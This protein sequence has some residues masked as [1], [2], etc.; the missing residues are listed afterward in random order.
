LP[1]REDER[2]Q[3]TGF[4]VCLDFKK[5]SL[6]N[7]PTMAKKVKTVLRLQLPAGAA[8]PAPPVGTVLGPQGINIQNFCKQ[9]NEA[10]KDMKGDVVPAQITIFE[11]RS[12]S[13]VLKTPPASVTKADVRT[14]AERKMP[15]LN[16]TDLAAAE[17]II[18]GTA[19]NMG[20]E[21]VG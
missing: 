10:T 19:K 20:I 14:I 12:F 18:A 7:V 9:F 4:Q 21:I 1:L 15:D 6:Y 5:I 11:D 2:R 16:T 8:N 17:R 13:F 3:S